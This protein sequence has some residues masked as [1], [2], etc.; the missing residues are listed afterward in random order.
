MAD[1]LSCR[2]TTE[3]TFYRSLL[4]LMVALV[5]THAAYAQDGPL[6]RHSAVGCIGR[7]D[8]AI[9]TAAIDPRDQVRVARAY[10]RSSAYPDFYYVEMRGAG[11]SFEGILPKPGPETQSIMYYIEAID[12]AFNSARTPENDADVAPSADECKR[13]DP[14][15]AHFGGENPGIAV[16]AT[17]KGAPA[18]PPGFLADGIVRF[19]ST[20][21]TAAAAG[22]GGG[23]GTPA[24]VAFGV[25]A[26]AA[27]SVGVLGLSEGSGGGGSAD[28]V[29]TPTTVPPGNGNSST[30]TT[31]IVSSGAVRACFETQPNP[32][33]ITAGNRVR[34]D[35]RCSQPAGLLDY[36]WDL[37]DGRTRTDPFIEPPYTDP[38][39]YL[40]RL[41]VRSTTGLGQDTTGRTIT[42]SAPPPPPPPPT[43][44]TTAPPTPTADL[45]IVKTSSLGAIC[46]DECD[47]FKY[48]LSVTNRGADAATNVVVRDAFPV[49]MQLESKEPPPIGCG[50]A[51]TPKTGVVVTCTLASLAAGAKVDLVF[52]VFADVS[53]DMIITNAASVTGT[54]LD[55]VSTNNTDSV[56]VCVDELE[57][58][59]SVILFDRA[60][61]A[62]TLPS[63]FISLLE[64]NAH[65]ED[66]RGSVVLNETQVEAVRGGSPHRQR[67][68]GREGLNTIEAFLTSGL[69]GGALWHF[70]FTGAEHFVAGSI[71]VESGDVVDT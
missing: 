13:Q 2:P 30:T 68:E 55:P 9:V 21:G 57:R 16:G 64:G 56:P 60:L 66:A 31:T 7:G 27:A 6:I 62:D 32:P 29:A 10:F 24:I 34:M 49:G 41:T 40:V 47:R 14:N 52:T 26:A 45:Q 59:C 23:I 3:G 51:G 70:D 8:Y 58:D 33:V 42:V 48:S 1:E 4:G 37:G 44:T 38:G 19:V 67:M 43:T 25:G 22:A 15:A 50:A 46:V 54:Q 5:A 71:S 35:G 65:A 28:T 11:P 36:F 20:A 17:V 53:Q 18:L 12:L 69:D 39:S 63:S 61:K